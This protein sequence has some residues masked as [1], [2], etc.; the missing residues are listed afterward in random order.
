MS[1]GK[2]LHG[3]SYHLSWRVGSSLRG[4][5]VHNTIVFVI[6]RRLQF[7]GAPYT[8]PC[9]RKN[10]LVAQPNALHPEDLCNDATREF[11]TDPLKWHHSHT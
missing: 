5:Y 4:G 1:I 3:S 7:Y 11:L 6:F 9:C 8:Q 2:V 10:V